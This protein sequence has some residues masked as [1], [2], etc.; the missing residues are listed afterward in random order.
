MKEPAKKAKIDEKK[1]NAANLA[2]SSDTETESE[3]NGGKRGR[4]TSA[5]SSTKK[6]VKK[7]TSTY[8]DG[9]STDEE[10]KVNLREKKQSH[11]SD[12]DEEM[13]YEATLEASRKI[14]FQKFRR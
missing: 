12:H 14:A 3:D 5:K 1:Y 6:A 2:S 8:A 10:I 11:H 9:P 7:E 13:N 4:N